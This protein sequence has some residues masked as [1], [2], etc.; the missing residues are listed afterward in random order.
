MVRGEPLKLRD[1]TTALVNHFSGDK[2]GNHESVAYI[3]TPTVWVMVVVSS[4][5]EPTYKASL[6]AFGDLVR[7]YEFFTTK[8]DIRK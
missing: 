2:W 7:S 4:R 5:E 1:G 8:V 6:P 3:E